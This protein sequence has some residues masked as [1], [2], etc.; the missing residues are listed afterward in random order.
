METHQNC[1]P[2][3]VLFHQMMLHFFLFLQSD[4]K[5]YIFIEKSKVYSYA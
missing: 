1:L 3:F 5:K 4:L 2:E